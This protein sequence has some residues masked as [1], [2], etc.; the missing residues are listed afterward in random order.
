MPRRDSRVENISPA[1]WY[2]RGVLSGPPAPLLFVDRLAGN[3]VI[4][5]AE[6]SIC[7]FGGEVPGSCPR[8]KS[9]FPGADGRP[10][11]A[12]VDVR[13]G[14]GSVSFTQECR[15][16]RQPGCLCLYRLMVQTQLAPPE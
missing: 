5:V 1:V 13:E 14:R 3:V 6:A 10:Q 8:F 4:I 7:S 11:G 16:A 9:I 15:C 12:G 2:D